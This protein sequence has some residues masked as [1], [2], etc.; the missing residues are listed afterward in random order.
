MEEKLVLERARRE[1]RGLTFNDVLLRVAYSEVLPEEA[2]LRSHFSRNVSLK[3]PFVSA[4][5]DTVT[6]HRLAIELAE[7][8]GIGIIH[9]NLTPEQQADEVARVKRNLNARVEKPVCVYE[10]QSIQ[11]VL[12]LADENRYDFRS[13][14]VLNR[15]GKLV[16]LVTGND[17]DLCRNPDDLVRDVMTRGVL[18]ESRETD[19]GSAYEIMTREKKKVLPLVDEQGRVVGMYVFSD[20]ERIKTGSAEKF[21]VDSNNRLRVGAAV[22]VGTEAYTRV[23]KLVKEGVDVI[24]IDTAHGNSKNVVETLREIKG[25]FD[26]DVVVGNIGYEDA[27]KRLIDAGADGLKVGI[28][29]GR[30]CTT[31]IVAGVGVPQVSAV[32]NCARKTFELR[33]D[34]PI[35][36][37]GGVKYSG[38]IAILIAAGAHSVMMGGVFSGTDETPGE[39]VEKRGRYKLYRGMGSIGAMKAGKGAMD[40]YSHP[41]VESDEELVPEGIEGLVPCKGPLA[42]IVHQYVGG[43]RKGMGYAGA[44]T[45]E[46]LRANGDFTEVSSAGASESHPGDVEHVKSSPNY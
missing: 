6:E 44:K 27:V 7:L 41:E 9:R 3:I 24:V 10:D 20:V 35:C 18:T 17:F 29:P 42:R 46:D 33:S 1:K 5:M 23:S 2:D 8:G 32:Y 31:R 16:G 40:R 38:D 45:I 12:T 28:G 30:I 4:A 26:V 22:G 36:A 15:E 21:N 19:I 43:L 13:F 25:N 37:D 14:P 39:I 34:V 11:S